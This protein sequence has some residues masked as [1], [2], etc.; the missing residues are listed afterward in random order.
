VLQALVLVSYKSNGT[1][2]LRICELLQDANQKVARACT[3]VLAALATSVDQFVIDALFLPLRDPS[4]IHDSELRCAALDAL[5]EIHTECDEDLASGVLVLFKKFLE[6]EK[7][8]PPSVE[9]AF[10]HLLG[11]IT[12]PGRRETVAALLE[13][14]WVDH[15]P[16]VKEAAIL[17]L[18]KVAHRGDADVMALAQEGMME[19]NVNVRR[20]SWEAMSA[21]NPI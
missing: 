9:I 3:E 11:K 21:L 18:S 2:L 6:I 16:L 1:V 14:G 19:A 8:L 10:L 5:V 17:A 4:E 7:G 20:A 12:P 13:R 15:R